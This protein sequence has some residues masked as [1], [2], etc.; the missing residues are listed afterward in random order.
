MGGV[1]P[2]LVEECHVHLKGSATFFTS[3]HPEPQNSWINHDLAKF[4][5]VILDLRKEINRVCEPGTSLSTD[6]I[7]QLPEEAYNQFEVSK[8]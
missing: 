8:A 1:L 2:H 3:E 5:E 4:V 7:L 6:V